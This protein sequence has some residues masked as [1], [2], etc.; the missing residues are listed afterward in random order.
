M[1]LMFLFVFMFPVAVVILRLLALYCL[2]ELSPEFTG[3]IS[4]GVSN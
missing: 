2:R 1:F 4:L 3:L